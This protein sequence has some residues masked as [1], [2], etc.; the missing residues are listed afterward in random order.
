MNLR[1][2]LTC[3]IKAMLER[4]RVKCGIR[5]GSSFTIVAK[6]GQS[7]PEKG[8]PSEWLTSSEWGSTEM[9]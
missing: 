2:A 1:I 4:A 8:L 7:N 9:H 5:S 6:T 3:F